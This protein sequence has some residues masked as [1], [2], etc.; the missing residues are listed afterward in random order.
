MAGMCL[1]MAFCAAVLYVW[2]VLFVLNL[3]VPLRNHLF[4]WLFFGAVS[5]F[6]LFLYFAGAR[7]TRRDRELAARL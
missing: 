4:S 3:A 7:E 5:V 6:F 1:V 2:P